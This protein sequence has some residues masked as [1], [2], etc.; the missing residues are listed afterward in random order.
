MK[1]KDKR[2]GFYIQ[3]TPEENVM[4][5][6]LRSKHAVNISQT[7]KNH[8]RKLFKQLENDNQ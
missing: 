2:L 8:L 1:T 5:K 3:L 7:I 4:I 6:S